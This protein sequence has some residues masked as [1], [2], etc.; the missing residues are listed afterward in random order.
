ML[1]IMGNHSDT[2]KCYQ[3]FAESNHNQPSKEA[4]MATPRLSTNY[5][6]LLTNNLSHHKNFSTPTIGRT[7]FKGELS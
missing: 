6:H 5:A 2:T 1:P 7:G 4:D 3:H